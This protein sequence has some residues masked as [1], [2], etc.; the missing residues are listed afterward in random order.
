[1]F[2]GCRPGEADESDMGPERGHWVKRS[3]HTKQRKV[4]KVWQW[5]CWKSFARSERSAAT[6]NIYS[7]G[8]FRAS[9]SNRFGH[10]VRRT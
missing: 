8:R 4:H 9:R 2:T 5:P 10:L 7:R 6:I 1:M 3:A